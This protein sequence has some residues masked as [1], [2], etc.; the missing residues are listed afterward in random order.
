MDNNGRVLVGENYAKIGLIQVFDQ[1]GD[2]LGIIGDA[3][4]QKIR[5][6]VPSDLFIDQENR[7]YVV[8]MY[9]SVI[10]VYSF[11]D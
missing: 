8:Q 10:S 11:V 3:S 2:L 4:K 7:L 1:Q 6:Q 5:F 9:T